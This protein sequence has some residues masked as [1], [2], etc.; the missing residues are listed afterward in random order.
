MASERTKELREWISF[1]LTIVTVLIIPT[2]L[3]VLRNQKLELK[4]EIRQE[5]VTIEAYKAGVAALA[6]T[7]A[8]AKAD[9]VAVNAKLD[10]IQ[11]SLARL[12]DAVKLKDNP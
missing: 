10:K 3:L 1:V 6:V 8:T 5:Y 9:L 4:D 2:G 7:D 11:I 12:M